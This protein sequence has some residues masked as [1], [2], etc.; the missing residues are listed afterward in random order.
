M[1]HSMIYDIILNKYFIYYEYQTSIEL[2][3]IIF[4]INV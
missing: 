1:N 4:Q 3:F 2:Q